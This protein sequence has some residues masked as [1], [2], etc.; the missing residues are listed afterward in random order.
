MIY[1]TLARITGGE[2]FQAWKLVDSAALS[3]VFEEMP[4]GGAEGLHK[5]INVQQLFF[6]LEGSATFNLEGVIY[7]LK[8]HQSIYVYPG[9]AH[10]IQNNSNDPIKF[11][12]ISNPHSHYDRVDL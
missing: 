12:V 9:Q 6:I 3:V 2:Q 11:L 7:E 8:A 10:F 5:H 1:P 4:A